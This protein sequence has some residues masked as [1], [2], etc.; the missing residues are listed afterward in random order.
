MAD[1]KVIQGGAPTASTTLINT[2]QVTITGDGSLDHPLVAEGGAIAVVVDNVSIGGDGTHAQ[3]LHT[4]P[5]GTKVL[6]DG[7]T[8]IGSGITGDPLIA[9]GGAPGTTFVQPFSYVVTGSEPDPAN[10][11]IPVSPAQPDGNYQLVVSQGTRSFFYGMAIPRAT[12][13]GANFVLALSANSVAGDTFDFIL[14]RA[15]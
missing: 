11:T 14:S 3:P 8:I 6:T 15:S 2:D 1:G 9:T 4:L 7:T 5:D 10:I 13:T 12:K